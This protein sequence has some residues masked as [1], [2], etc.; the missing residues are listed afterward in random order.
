[1]DCAAFKDFVLC[2]A[3]D[4]VSG[5]CA[6]RT[7]LHQCCENGEEWALRVST[8]VASVSAVISA[9]RPR[10]AAAQLE[11]GQGVLRDRVVDAQPGAGH[12]RVEHI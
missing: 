7:Y 4:V 6:Y 8:N 1:M 9:G 3:L 5:N 10:E 12:P 2:K 11:A